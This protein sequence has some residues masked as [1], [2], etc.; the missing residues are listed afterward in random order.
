MT[1]ICRKSESAYKWFLEK[2]TAMVEQP[3]ASSETVSEIVRSDTQKA[4]ILREML[5]ADLGI[6]DVT[7]KSVSGK[8]GEP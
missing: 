4:R 8:K 6:S 3:A 5:L 2:L 1:G 7:I